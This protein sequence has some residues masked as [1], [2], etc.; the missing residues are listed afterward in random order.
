[1]FRNSLT[2]T[3]TLKIMN[4]SINKRMKKTAKI[5]KCPCS[6]ISASRHA[7][8]SRERKYREKDRE[9]G[10]QGKGEIARERQAWIEKEFKK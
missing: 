8:E 3:T 7:Q 2:V 10:G 5:R 9:I 1:M 4:F 6:E